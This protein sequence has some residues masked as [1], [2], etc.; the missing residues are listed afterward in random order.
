MRSPEKEQGP[1]LPHQGWEP[2]E[3]SGVG[4]GNQVGGGGARTGRAG[5]GTVRHAAQVVGA[6]ASAVIVWLGLAG[7]GSSS[8]P[9]QAPCT[10]SA[11]CSTGQVCSQGACA[12]CS[13]ST[14]PVPSI[15][16]PAA[17][18]VECTGSASAPLTPPQ[19][20]VSDVCGAIVTSPPA[21]RYPMGTTQLTYTATDP[22]GQ[23]ATCT[24][25]AQVV[26]ST[27]PLLTCPADL[28]A[29][30]AGGGAVV[31]PGLAT[32]T[33]QCSAVTVSNLP[34]GRFPLGTT[35]VTHSATDASG[36][37]ATCTQ[38]IQVVDSAPPQVSAGP[39]GGGPARAI[40]PQGA[41]L[42]AVDLLV[43]C[44]LSASDVCQGPLT[45]SAADA[46]A[47]CVTVNEPALRS[48]GPDVVFVDGT[49]LLLLGRSVGTG[50]GR[51]Y[52]IQV[53]VQDASGNVATAT[54]RVDVGPGPTFPADAGTVAQT[55]CPTG[56]MCVGGRCG[57]PFFYATAANSRSSAVHGFSIDAATGALTELPASP[58]AIP[59]LRLA[60]HPSGKFLYA[61]DDQASTVSA[62][63]V[64]RDG[65]LTSVG[66][67]LAT[68]TYPEAATVDPSGAHLYVGSIFGGGVSIYAIDPAT[69]GLTA[70]SPLA[71]GLY[72]H[73][74]ALDPAGKWLYLSQNNADTVTQYQVDPASGQLSGP[75][76]LA[77]SGGYH[78]AMDP[79]GR[80]LFVTDW[81]K[82]GA[83]LVSVYAISPAD[84]TLT[85]VEDHVTGGVDPAGLAVTPDGR[86]LYVANFASAT[87]AMFSVG[88]DGKLTALAGSP[89]G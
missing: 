34:K 57:A 2:T 59:G 44:Q 14:A 66:K 20:T 8:G 45:L 9:G 75:R 79:Q 76:T 74:I 82:T 10:T 81:D 52:R 17:V 51:I 62:F 1:S 48:G 26:D 3:A 28:T 54:C 58:F 73:G 6:W 42:T 24:T 13:A 31:D 33:D 86:H 87:L 38:R 69:G 19:A 63:A 7:C 61:T 50:G 89:P 56:P 4:T 77:A 5:G 49:H 35:Q 55:L 80:F 22:W 32:A 84:G 64:G 85:K 25:A 21:G 53:Q 37:G 11:Q 15:S 67:P 70:E 12:A 29:E 23:T 78:S 83:D 71:S 68:G 30:C 60:A 41:T 27:P 16:C 65:G 18:T 40:W 39:A 46:K 88:A 47:G 36:N 72:N 43:D